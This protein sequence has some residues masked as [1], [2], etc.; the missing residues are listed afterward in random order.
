MGERRGRGGG[1]ARAR[2][3]PPWARRLPAMVGA[4]G[5]APAL[6]PPA[7]PLG[8]G[9]NHSGGV[10]GG[11]RGPWQGAPPPRAKSAA[12]SPPPV[13]GSRGGLEPRAL[14]F[15][16]GA[17][18]GVRWG[19]GR[20]DEDRGS[21]RRREF[22]TNKGR[23]DDV[24]P[25]PAARPWLSGSTLRPPPTPRK[26]PR[27]VGPTL[28]RPPPPATARPHA[29]DDGAPSRGARRRAVGVGSEGKARP[30]G[31]QGLSPGPPDAP[32][33]P[34]PSGP[35]R[36]RGPQRARRRRHTTSR[37]LPP[38]THPRVNLHTPT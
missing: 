32:A 14:N 20:T 35:R 24:L 33:C 26:E 37:P 12:S 36:P 25:P 19:G 5:S 3:R 28:H 34:R 6:L 7:A 18:V 13:P 4:V 16:P 11:G 15:E 30:R 2:S 17:D 9:P 31:P 38:V 29:P 10:A 1:G 23:P 8:G 21:N 22:P 27:S